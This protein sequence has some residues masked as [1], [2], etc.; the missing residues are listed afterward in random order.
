MILIISSTEL[1]K[2]VWRRWA[3]SDIQ[4]INSF[5]DVVSGTSM[6]NFLVRCSL[7]SQEEVWMTARRRWN[8]L[9]RE[10]MAS[11]QSLMLSSLFLLYK[12]HLGFS[13]TIQTT[14]SAPSA[15]TRP[16]AASS[17][18]AESLSTSQGW[19]S[20]RRR[21]RGRLSPLASVDSVCVFTPH[22]AT[23]EK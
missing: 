13:P 12:R 10:V 21:T 1:S 22:L 20:L 4:N 5:L 17:S 19:G 15:A 11:Q 7:W 16:A 18:R 23:S 8:W 3:C 9:R 6:G 14:F 2:L